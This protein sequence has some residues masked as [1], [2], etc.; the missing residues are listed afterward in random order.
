MEI[1]ETDFESCLK[2]AI[3]SG[4]EDGLFDD[5]LEPMERLRVETFEERG[6]A[7]GSSGLVV[8]IGDSEFQVS[9]VR[10]R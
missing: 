2:D 10:S 1:S 5:V 9:I 6:F 4:D 3:E 7:G 8:R